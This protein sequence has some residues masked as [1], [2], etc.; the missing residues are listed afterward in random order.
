M[1]PRIDRQST[2]DLLQTEEFIAELQQRIDQADHRILIQLMT[3]DGDDSGQDVANRLIRAVERGVKVR[4]LVDCFVLRFVSDQPVTRAAVQPEAAATLAMY[5][6]LRE[7]GVDLTF[8]H[9]HG[10]G[11]LFSLA[12]N[13]K[14]LFVIDDDVYLGGINVSDHNF[15]WHD[16]MIRID[17]DTVLDEVV[18]DF[19]FTFAGG[20][21]SVNSAIITNREVENV[22][23]SLLRNAEQ[24]VE[25]A[26]PYAIDVGLTRVLANVAAPHKRVI[27]TKRNNLLIY[28]AMSPFLKWKLRR[29]GTKL[30]SYT[31]FSHSKFLLVDDNKLLIGSSNF[32]RHSFWCNQEICLL[33]TDTEFIERFKATLMQEVEP[34]D[35]HLPAIK[36][37]FGALVSYIM[38][39][40]VIGLRY[41]VA[42]RVPN[43]SRR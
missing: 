8:T 37:A 6:R 25:L 7:A 38:Y 31:N 30:A 9:P 13:H 15:S 24:S 23:D 18:D 29:S 41:T 17:D 34:M 19:E 21:R 3:F 40:S 42:P 36:V 10:P 33:I 32:G 20:R 28:R 16:F 43:L 39:G 14:K 11:N 12:R 4:L 2:Y 22:F 35:E 1:A 27:A 5:D 26:S